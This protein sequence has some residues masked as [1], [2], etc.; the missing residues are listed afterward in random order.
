MSLPDRPHGSEDWS[1]LDEGSLR[2]AA[3]E[4]SNS[5]YRDLSPWSPVGGFI[6]EMFFGAWIIGGPAWGCFFTLV[7]AWLLPFLLAVALIALAIAFAYS[8][9]PFAGA[10]LALLSGAFIFA[11]FRYRLPLARRRPARADF[12]IGAPERA[13]RLRALKRFRER[14]HSGRTGPGP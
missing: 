4:A 13:E 7:L 11:V 12:G 2:E 10:A 8:W 6:R 14:W 5:S 9:S 1:A 3:T